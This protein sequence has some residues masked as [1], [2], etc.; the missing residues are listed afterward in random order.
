MMLADMIASSLLFL[1]QSEN[2]ER[3]AYNFWQIRVRIINRKGFDLLDDDAY[4]L[5]Q[6]D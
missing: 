4:F 1:L 2:T 6:S 3:E 5:P